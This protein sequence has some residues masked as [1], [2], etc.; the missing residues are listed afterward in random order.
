MILL[1]TLGTSLVQVGYLDTPLLITSGS[2]AITVMTPLT[3][4]VCLLLLWY[5]VDSLDRERST[6]LAEIV[7][8][9][10][11]APDRSCWARPWP[12]PWRA[13]DRVAAGL[14]GVIA[15]L[16]QGR[17]RWNSARSALLG[18]L[19]VPDLPGLDVRL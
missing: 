14:G 6:R 9:H 13:G 15:I 12:W 4:C 19:L 11:S 17:S 3:V 10:R 16:F 7:T 2:F 5:T 1:Q 18:T 8:P